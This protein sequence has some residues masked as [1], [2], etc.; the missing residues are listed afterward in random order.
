MRVIPILLAS[1]AALVS[2]S[3]PKKPITSL[4]IGIKHRVPEELCTKRSHD[5]DTL[6]MHYTGTLYDTG[7]KF[8]SSLD[9]NEPLQFTLGS[10]QVIKGFEAG[11]KNMC[12]GEK[13]RLKIPPHLAYGS[14]GAGSAIPGNA[15][16]VFD[17][18]L[19]DVKPGHRA[20]DKNR[21][22]SQISHDDRFEQFKSP[23][24]IISTAIVVSL[25]AVMYL[26]SRQSATDNS[27]KTE[28]EPAST[29]S[30]DDDAK[31]KSSPKK[32]NKNKARAD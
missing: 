31:N 29:S 12:V 21:Q 27:K 28:K 23:L 9:R 20:F 5:G 13:R 3:T 8:D 15:A 19:V 16:L 10:G 32:K 6:S 7:A 24:F 1:F 22:S 11:L 2:A 18:E 25:F 14:Q 17:V 4:Q 26:H 30:N